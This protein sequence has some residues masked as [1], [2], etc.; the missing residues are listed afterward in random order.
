[1][2]HIQST[3]AL[4]RELDHALYLRFVADIDCD[5]GSVSA[6][7]R[8]FRLLFGGLQIDIGKDNFGAL[9]RERLRT[10]GADAGT[11]A[12]HDSNLVLHT[13]HSRAPLFTHE[14]SVA[15]FN[16]RLYALFCV[17][18][19]IETLLGSDDLHL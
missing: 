6:A 8:D 2:Q 13:I 7:P 9:S 1:M 10:S 16:E 19:V 17:F 18:S 11:S 14:A 12:G 15:F 5:S 3:E 4:H